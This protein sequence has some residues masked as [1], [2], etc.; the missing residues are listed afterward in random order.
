MLKLLLRPRP[1]PIE[2]NKLAFLAKAKNDTFKAHGETY[3]FYHWKGTGPSILL[4]HGWESNSSRWRPLIKQLKENNYNIYALDGPAHGNSSG[5]EF[6]PILFAEA[7]HHVIESKQIDIILGHS[8]G[9]F[10]SLYYLSAYTSISL[11]KAVILAPTYSM[12]DVF[13]GMKKILSLSTR[14]I[15]ALRKHF[16][17]VYDVIPEEFNSVNFI[18]S[19]DIPTLLIHDVDDLTLPIIGSDKIAEAWK[20]CRYEKTSGYGHRLRH[21]SVD[22]MI[23]EFISD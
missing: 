19:V 15:D 11:K 8:A 2:K 6:T 12:E 17:Q 10:A 9:G 3:T 23:I 20:S 5:N 7:A 21:T 16:I 18:Q 14:S 13:K 4:L 22:A 1:K